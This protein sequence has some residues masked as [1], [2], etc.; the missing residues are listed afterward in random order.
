MPVACP[1]RDAYHFMYNNN[2]GGFC[3]SPMSYTH[4]CASDSQLQFK[5]NKCTDAAYTHDLGEDTYSVSLL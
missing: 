2:T 3:S 4:T 5:F 1:F